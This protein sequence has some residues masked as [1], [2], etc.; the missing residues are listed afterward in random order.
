MLFHN[1]IRKKN[2]E[3]SDTVNI[4]LFRFENIL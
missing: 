2:T 3:T 4:K 1:D